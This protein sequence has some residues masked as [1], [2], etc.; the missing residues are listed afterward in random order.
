MAAAVHLRFQTRARF[1]PD[2]ERADALWPID[3][4]RRKAH[5]VDLQFGEVDVGL[6]GGLGG[7]DVEEDA[8]VTADFADFGNRLDDADLAIDLHHRDENGVGP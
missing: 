1:A 5:Q 8:L 4:V 3:F 6:A 2:V 7:V